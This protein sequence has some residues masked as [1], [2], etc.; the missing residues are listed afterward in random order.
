MLVLICC[1][2]KGWGGQLCC[3]AKQSLFQFYTGPL[4]TVSLGCRITWKGSPQPASLLWVDF[5]KLGWFCN[6]IV[7]EHLPVLE[8]AASQLSALQRSAQEDGW[9]V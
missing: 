6:Q 3:T 5:G 4:V 2:D 8:K 9:P 1:S 7:P